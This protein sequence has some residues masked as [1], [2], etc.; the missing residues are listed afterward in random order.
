MSGLGQ[1]L[2]GAALIAQAFRIANEAV[3][4]DI[5]TEGIRDHDRTDG[6]WFD[7]RPMFDPREHSPEVIDM[8]T[9]AIA[10]ALASGVIT[11]DP[12]SAHLVRI[13]QGA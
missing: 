4:S 5:E 3:V 8:N 11:A 6:R 10:Y 1:L 13:N 7:I 12:Q 2:S 9:E